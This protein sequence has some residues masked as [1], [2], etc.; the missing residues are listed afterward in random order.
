MEEG[1]GGRDGETGEA[2]GA[3]SVTATGKTGY[4]SCVRDP[5]GDC[6]VPVRSNRNV[7]RQVLAILVP[8]ALDTTPTQF[9]PLLSR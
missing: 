8:G 6:C 3:R 5:K 9:V 1:R 4:V 2:A 7:L